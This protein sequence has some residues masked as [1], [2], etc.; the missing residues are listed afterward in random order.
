MNKII[1][2]SL[3]NGFLEGDCVPCNFSYNNIIRNPSMMLWLDKICVST[4]TWK[5]ITQSQNSRRK[6][7]RIVSK[8][9]ECY[10]KNNLVEVFDTKKLVKSETITNLQNQVERDVDILLDQFP[11]LFENHKKTTNNSAIVYKGIEYCYPNLYAIYGDLLLSQILKANCLFDIWQL[12]F[13]NLKFGL[14]AT[15]PINTQNKLLGIDRILST[16]FPNIHSL[17]QYILSSNQEKCVECKNGD[18]CEADYIES[19]D[20][21]LKKYSEWRKYDEVHQIRKLLNDITRE[22]EKNNDI[23]LPEDIFNEFVNKKNEANNKLHKVFPKVE[24]WSELATYI[25][26]STKAAAFMIGSTEVAAASIAAE[27]AS[28]ALKRVIKNKNKKYKWINFSMHD[29]QSYGSNETKL[30]T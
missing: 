19:L 17:P 21:T 16:F 13:C 28:I 24:K 30:I 7:T 20:N 12:E 14:S 18:K 3:Q 1:V 23:V 26:F 6:I 27:G 8:I 4:D 25:S 29:C 5:T 15:N 22:C 9:F 2:S 10:E 11:N